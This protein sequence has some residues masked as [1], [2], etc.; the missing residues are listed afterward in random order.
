MWHL[1]WNGSLWHK[2]GVVAVLLMVPAVL[3][4]QDVVSF[5]TSDGGVVF[6]DLYGDGV[7]GVILAP[8][9]RFDKS[10]WAPQANVLADAGFR[11]L[12]IDFRGHGESRAGRSGPDALPL[13]VL[14]A[15][16]YLRDLG[17]EQIA[18]VGASIGGWAAGEAAVESRMDTTIGISRLVFLAHSSI[19]QPERLPGRKLFI[20]SRGDTRGAGAFLRLDAIRSQYDA[21]PEPKELVVVEGSAHAQ[22][23][24]QAAEGDQV[25]GEILR[26][27]LAP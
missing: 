2:V 17:T 4:A 18:V 3:A 15:V 9:G 24:F 8:G 23:L 21:A 25:M 6:G 11:V 19:S 10:S 12:A 26:F 20:V 5:P 1:N 22:F 27:L 16:R 13:D 7:N 14:A